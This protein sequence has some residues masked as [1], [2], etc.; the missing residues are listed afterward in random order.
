MDEDRVS[1][2]LFG[3]P[4]VDLIV[5]PRPLTDAASLDLSSPGRDYLVQGTVKNCYMNIII[6]YFI[7]FEIVGRD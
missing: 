7:D 2:F 6:M 4:K 5:P 1:K 3:F